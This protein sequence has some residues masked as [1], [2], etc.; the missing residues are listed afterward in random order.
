M[1]IAIHV[2]GNLVHFV[3]CLLI[4]PPMN[5]AESFT[6]TMYQLDMVNP[7]TCLVQI[8]GVFVIF[9]HKGP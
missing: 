6:D 3:V 1:E 2:N 7:I 9:A 5:V 8:V 4:H